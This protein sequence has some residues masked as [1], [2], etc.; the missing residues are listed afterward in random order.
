MAARSRA[1]RGSAAT[2]DIERVWL[3]PDD[4]RASRGRP[5]RDRRGR[6]HRDR[7]GQP[8]HQHPAEPAP[9][10]IRAALAASSALR[11]YVCN[12]A[13]QTGETA[14]FDLADHVEAL[15][16]HT[17]EGIV[18][19]VLANNRIAP[20]VPGAAANRSACAGPR[21]ARDPPASS[22][23]ILSIRPAQSTTTPSGWPPRSSGSPSAKVRPAGAAASPGR[24]EGR[25]VR[26]AAPGFG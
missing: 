17:A 19:I 3:S 4:V 23:M 12:V 13:T 22:S 20:L 10:D 15:E 25:A 24:P 26:A 1:S 9:A 18:D 6:P 11:I 5:R 2:T 8:V 14:G 16:R 21:P 7:P